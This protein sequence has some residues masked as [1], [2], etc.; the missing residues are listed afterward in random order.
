MT[1][2]RITGEHMIVDP[3]TDTIALLSKGLAPQG[4]AQTIATHASLIFLGTDR[5]WKLKR[6]VLF[7]YLDYSTPQRRL[8][9]CESELSL[10]RRTAPELYLGVRHVTRNADG[11]LTLDGEGELVDAFVEM[12]RFDE[13]DLLDRMAQD[14]RL[15]CGHMD[16]L[17][18]RIATFHASAEVF[19]NRGGAA[20]IARV[21]AMNDEALR[22]TGLVADK[23]ASELAAAMRVRLDAFQT[24]LDARRAAGK[25]R[26]CHGDMILR[27][28]Y[29][30]EGQPT[31]FD[32]IEFD[33][34]IATI[35]VL[36]DLAFLLMD[37]WHRDRRDL[38]NVLMNRYLDEAEETEGLG[39]L[40]F[41]MAIRATIRAHV[42]AAQIDRSLADGAD[43]LRDEA[44]RYF[45]LA[46]FLLAPSSVSLVAVGGLSGSGKSTLAAGLAPGIGAPP[47]ARHLNS[48]RIRKR[49]YGV[50]PEQT[51]PQDAY[52]PTV[53][54]RVYALMHE[55]AARVLASGWSVILDAVYDRADERAK[56]AHVAAGAQAQFHGYWL[57]AATDLRLAR[58]SARPKGPS[59][60]T[61]EI[62][63]KQENAACGDMEWTRL[64]AARST[65]ELSEVIRLDATT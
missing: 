63:R 48:D 20:G 12:R 45:E 11:N 16:A 15:T 19:N 62:A 47:G 50:R 57:Q 55:E 1:R 61:P 7:P 9:A 43:A 38:A 4:Q 53:S 10:N 2:R 65:E 6:A 56:A 34:E 36:Y 23:M 25:V 35:D 31:L 30:A 40:P 64:D 52:Q 58:V 33:E 32:C 46:R 29:L 18:R 3:Q 22:A 28:I 60:A 42:T 14:G 39:L 17:A 8:A 5:V 51:L 37:L 49:L 54:A 26:R 27:N 21:I 44:L 41:F 24:L 13:K 59:D